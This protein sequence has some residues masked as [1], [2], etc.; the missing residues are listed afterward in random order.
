MPT[1][2][3]DNQAIAVIS[4][5]PVLAEQQS[6]VIDT[7][8]EAVSD[9]Q[10]AAGYV[11]TSLHKSLDGVK[12]AE[13]A[14]W[15]SQA[16]FERFM[17][18]GAGQMLT[19]KLAAVSE[20]DQHVYEIVVSESRVGPPAIRAGEYIVHFAEF[21]MVPDNQ[22]RMVALAKE[23]VGPAM[24][25][26][27]LISANFHRSLDGLRVINYGQWRDRDTI[28]ELRKQPGFSS[29]QPYWEGLAENQY[30]LYEVVFTDP[31]ES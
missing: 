15:Q 16:D 4:L 24:Q 31:A 25:F 14:Q 28:E 8:R 20:P 17:L 22:P 5:Y 19:G 26:E 27:G 3:L 9:Y 2:S 29:E 6:L 7:L 30:H 1:L 18:S 21:R 13:Y 23:H 12:V 11:S 10:Q